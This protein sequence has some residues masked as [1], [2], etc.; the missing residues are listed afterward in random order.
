MARFSANHTLNPKFL[1]SQTGGGWKEETV[2][3]LALLH[4]Q[5]LSCEKKFHKAAI[6]EFDK[7]TNLQEKIAR[8]NQTLI[9]GNQKQVG[10]LIDKSQSGYRT[11]F[12]LCNLSGSQL[13][14]AC[15]KV[16]WTRWLFYFLV[17]Y[18]QSNAND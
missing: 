17:R 9:V 1:R 16:I 4:S 12:L 5:S 14:A 10:Y 8:T 2:I 13:L 18:T 7:F 15:H 6:L 3:G 11:P